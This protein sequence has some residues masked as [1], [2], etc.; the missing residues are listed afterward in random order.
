VRF[1]FGF[2]ESMRVM[3]MLQQLTTNLTPILVSH[4]T[5]SMTEKIEGGPNL[6][7][8]VDNVSH[9]ISFGVC[10]RGSQFGWVLSPVTVTRLAEALADAVTARK[11]EKRGSSSHNAGSP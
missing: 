10:D 3:A 8:T 7:F 1:F 4:H 6:S 2:F 11:L 9:G 5:F